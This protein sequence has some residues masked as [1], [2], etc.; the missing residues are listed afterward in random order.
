MG[1]IQIMAQKL[2]GQ[3]QVVKGKIEVAAGEPIHG[4]IDKVKG[5]A[6]IIAANMKMNIE[7]SKSSK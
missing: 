6:N 4:S 2:K 3:A 1:K 5:K 7:N